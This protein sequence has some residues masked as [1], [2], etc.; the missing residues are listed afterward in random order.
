MATAF[1]RWESKGFASTP[2]RKTAPQGGLLMYRAWGASSSEW[3][4]GYFSLEKPTSVLD[5]ELRFNIADWGNGVH[6]VST[7]RLKAGFAYYVG[8][9]ANGG[10][11]LSRRGTQVYVESPFVVQVERVGAMEVLRHDVSVVQKMGK[12]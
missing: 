7:F 6:F 1:D 2:E 11:D 8:P 12:A 5:A 4:S 3:G 10:C 9:V